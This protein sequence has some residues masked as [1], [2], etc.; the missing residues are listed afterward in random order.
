MSLVEEL[1]RVR[2]LMRLRQTDRRLPQFRVALNSRCG[3]ACFYCRPSGESLP[4]AAGASIEPDHLVR[5][6]SIVRQQG[7][8]SIKLTGGDPAL[9]GPLEEVVWRLRGEA[10]FNEIELISRSPLIGPQ[11]SGL[12]R[13]GVTLFNISID[14][15]DP[16][17]H[18]EIGGIDDHSELLSA[19]LECVATNV[20]C[21]VNSVVLGGINQAEI[22]DL[23]DFCGTAGIAS[24]KF[25]DVIRDLDLGRETFS[26]RVA[27]LRKRT[28]E[29]LHVP[30]DVIRA[31]L[32]SI[33]VR[34]ETVFQGDLGHPMTALTM[35]TGLRVILKDSWTGAWYGKICNGCTFFPCHDA[36]MALRLTPD[37]RLQFC[38]LNESVALPL[39]ALVVGDNPTLERTV[40]SALAQYANTHFAKA[41]RTPQLHA[42]ELLS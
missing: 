36:L 20:P 15:L 5:I 18:R 10:G 33:A 40:V 3:R 29:D 37:L 16:T 13:A 4:T 9:Y 25:L 27:R 12:A 23:V 6:A 39:E 35:P 21:K 17:L 26:R 42:I 28:L 2:Y 30:L 24:L 41:P 34:T 8:T 32:E 19:L 22:R 38:L 31:S 1:Y 14:T 7:V 11:A